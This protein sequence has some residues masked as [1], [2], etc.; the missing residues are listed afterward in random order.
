MKKKLKNKLTVQA[1]Q[2]LKRE[3]V[4]TG[5]FVVFYIVRILVMDL[6]YSVLVV[7][8]YLESNNT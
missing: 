2:R 7:I 3:S 4:V 1:Q 6:G 8:Y 5:V